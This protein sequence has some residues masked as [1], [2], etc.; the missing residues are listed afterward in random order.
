MKQK[1]NYELAANFSRASETWADNFHS[2]RIN[3]LPAILLSNDRTF[4]G[5]EIEWLRWRFLFGLW[6]NRNVI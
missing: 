2:F 5:I 4:I 6:K 1:I 3:L